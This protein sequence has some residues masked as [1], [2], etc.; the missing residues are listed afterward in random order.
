MT[1][2]ADLDRFAALLKAREKAVFVN[3]V[4][5]VKDSIQNGS[6]IT[7]APGQPVDTGN[8][9]ASWEASFES[10]QVATIATNVEYAPVIE[11]NLRGVTFHNHGPHSVKLTVAGFQKI[12]ASEVVKAGG[13]VSWQ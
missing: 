6:A 11:D 8:L 1:F 4:A 2:D 3:T 10:A 7:G 5:T 9:R 12:V 13:T